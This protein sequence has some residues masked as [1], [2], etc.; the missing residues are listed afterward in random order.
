MKDE[1]RRELTEN[2]VKLIKFYKDIEKDLLLNM[3]NNFSDKH[4]NYNRWKSI[5]ITH[6]EQGF[7]ALIRSIAEE[8]DEVKTHNI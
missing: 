1:H 4:V 7:M 3:N 6:F 5:A 2:Q 8:S